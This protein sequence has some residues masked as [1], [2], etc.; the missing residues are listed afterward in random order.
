MISNKR[1]KFAFVWFFVFVFFFI[2][3]IAFIEPLKVPLT[4]TMDALSCSTTSNEFIKPVC[5]LLKGG[6]VLFIGTFLIYLGRWTLFKTT[7]K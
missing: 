7:Q 1:G 2:V 4:D 5:F 3:A 6:V